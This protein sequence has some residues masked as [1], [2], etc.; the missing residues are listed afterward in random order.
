MLR[1]V[2]VVASL[3]VGSAAVAAPLPKPAAFAMCGACHK[4]E[5]GAPNGIGPNLWG[6]GG[7]VSGTVPG[8][9]YSP[10]MKNAKL[11]WNKANLT[12]YLANPQGKIPGNKMPFGGLKDPTQNAQVVDYL[13]SLK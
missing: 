8:F 1:V 10:A 13:L 4:A 6:V 9:A 12:A 3:I 7:R 2:A 11:P 5:K